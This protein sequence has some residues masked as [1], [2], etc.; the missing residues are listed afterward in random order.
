MP[1]STAPARPLAPFDTYPKL[2]RRFA[3]RLERIIGRRQERQ[4]V[5][6][7]RARRPSVESLEGRVVPASYTAES[8][9]DLVAAV[10]AANATA[11][12]DTITLAAGRTFTLDSFDMSTGDS[13]EGPAGL[14]AVVAGEDLTVVGN[15]D[16]IERSTNN[17]GFRFFNVAAG[18]TLTLRNLTLQGGYNTYRGGALFNRGTLT[19]DRVVVQNN[20][21]T[22]GGGVYSEGNL[23]IEGS[24]IRF[25]S[26]IG[27]RGYDG[28]YFFIG[29]W[30]AVAGGPGESSYGGGVTIGGGIASISNSTIRDNTARGGDGG[31]GVDAKPDGVR[32][33]TPAATVV[34]RSVAGSMRPAGQ[35]PCATPR[36]PRT[37]RWVAPAGGDPRGPKTACPG[38][39]SGVG[40][41]SSSIRPAATPSPRSA[42]TPSP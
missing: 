13:S 25:N 17:G 15:G 7:G 12:A 19:L 9:T 39:A 35:S 6:R 23:I 24:T 26:A 8:V 29:G 42:S 14:P 36:S 1:A 33:R 10:N 27:N 32:V 3:M 31:A 2:T 11:E 20:R 16:I 22:S 21:S 34:A 4:G 40:C 28:F 30:H 37:R 41:T 5:A 18:G 38:R